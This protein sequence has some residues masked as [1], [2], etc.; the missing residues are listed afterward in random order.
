MFGFDEP[1]PYFS[2]DFRQKYHSGNIYSANLCIQASIVFTLTATPHVYR[3]DFDL[4]SGLVISAGVDTI[5]ILEVD[6][7]FV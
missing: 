6:Y 3:I 1:P 4:T 7:G 2:L 5:S